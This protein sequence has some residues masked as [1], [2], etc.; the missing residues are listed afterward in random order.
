MNKIGQIADKVRSNVFIYY[1]CNCRVY[2][3]FRNHL[4]ERGQKTLSIQ[5][6]DFILEFW[7]LETQYQCHFIVFRSSVRQ[8]DSC[9]FTFNFE[10]FAWSSRI[11]YQCMFPINWIIFSLN[12]FVFSALF[13]VV[14]IHWSL[15]P[16][17]SDYESIENQQSYFKHTAHVI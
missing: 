6:S 15:R 2:V 1:I 9:S 14:S 7:L 11:Q 16:I 4:F 3:K 5:S 17:A 13:F 10:M 8:S 12:D